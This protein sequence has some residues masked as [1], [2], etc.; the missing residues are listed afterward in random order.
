MN[1]GCIFILLT[2]SKLFLFLWVKAASIVPLA[3][4]FLLFSSISQIPRYLARAFGAS[5]YDTR[6]F[7]VGQSALSVRPVKDRNTFAGFV[8]PLTPQRIKTDTPRQLFELGKLTYLTV[9]SA[10]FAAGVSLGTLWAGAS[11][12]TRKQQRFLSLPG[13]TDSTRIVK[14]WK[15]VSPDAPKKHA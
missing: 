10:S 3:S 12:G 14:H 5:S 4:Q 7:K 6:L 13:R 2:Y 9:V 1:S 15:D 8:F 11:R